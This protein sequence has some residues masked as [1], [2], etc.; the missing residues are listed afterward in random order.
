VSD[1]AEILL[2]C[3]PCEVWKHCGNLAFKAEK[4][5]TVHNCCHKGKMELSLCNHIL[6]F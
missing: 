6:S 5:W 4:G 1:E 3:V 2:I